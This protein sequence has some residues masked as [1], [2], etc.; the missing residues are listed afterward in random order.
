MS[1]LHTKTFTSPR[2][3]LISAFVATIALTLFGYVLFQARFLLEGPQL[4]LTTELG[5]LQTERQIVLEGTAKN[6]TA[7]SLN[8]RA[9]VT[10]EVGTFKEPVVLENGYTVIRIEARDRYGRTTSLERSFVYSPSG[11]AVSLVD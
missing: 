4:T 7:I 11:S 10:S 6:I 2:K 3:M 9:I 1:P 5:I 8:G